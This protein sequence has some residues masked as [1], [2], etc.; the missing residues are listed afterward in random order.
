MERL[1]HPPTRLARPTDLGF[2]IDLFLLPFKLL[3]FVARLLTPRPVRRVKRAVRTVANPV[4]AAQRAVTPRP[5]R[6]ARRAVRGVT[7]PVQAAENG[8]VAAAHRP[9]RRR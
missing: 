5:V 9:R 8:I 6:K 1:P 2:L 4:N 3:G 7:H